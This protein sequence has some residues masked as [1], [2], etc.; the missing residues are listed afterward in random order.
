MLG[1]RAGMAGRPED[2]GQVEP[3]ERLRQRRDRGT[4]VDLGQDEVVG[5]RPDRRKDRGPGRPDDG[6]VDR[7]RGGRPGAGAEV[8]ADAEDQVV[9]GL[10]R[11]EERAGCGHE[12]VDVREPL[13]HGHL[14]EAQASSAPAARPSSASASSASSLVVESS[15]I[16]ITRETPAA[17]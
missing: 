15:R 8:R 9:L 2:A 12:R 11:L 6:E 17:R 4:I 10:A 3:G 1:E 13:D 7:A 14:D 5:R 16:V